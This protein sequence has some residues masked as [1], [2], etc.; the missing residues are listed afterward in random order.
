MCTLDLQDCDTYYSP[1]F[2]QASSGRLDPSHRWSAVGAGAV[3]RRHPSRACDGQKPEARSPAPRLDRPRPHKPLEWLNSSSRDND[4][5]PPSAAVRCRLLPNYSIVN[6][7]VYHPN[8]CAV[9]T[10][11]GPDP[12][13]KFSPGSREFAVGSQH[14]QNAKWNGIGAGS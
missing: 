2:Q 10:K 8:V 9:H 4:N 11:S 7:H 3:R 14:A 1:P 13:T 6:K 5:P 12:A